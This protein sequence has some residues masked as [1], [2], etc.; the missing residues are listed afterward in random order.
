M[1]ERS[2]VA[3]LIK[4]D[5]WSGTLDT[6]IEK[7]PSMR[8]FGLVML[9]GFGLLG[10]LALWSWREAHVTWRLV[11]GATLVAIGTVIFLW[12]LVSPRT[13][14]PVYR[15]W[16]SFGQRIGTI[17]SSILL[18]VLYFVVFTIVGLLMRVFGTDPLE[19]KIV[20]GSG[21]YWRKH[22]PPSTAADYAHLS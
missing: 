7:P 9:V 1:T 20:R 5:R 10:G 11:L 19:R 21:T 13:L 3:P 17:V 14:P 15:G 22:A 2:D 16:M 6:P 4:S 12:S 18:S 8:I